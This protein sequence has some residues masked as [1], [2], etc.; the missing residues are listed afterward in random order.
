LNQ[1]PIWVPM[2]NK[3]RKQSPTEPEELPVNKKAKEEKESKQTTVWI[4]EAMIEDQLAERG[5]T[6]H[7]TKEGVR[8]VEAKWNQEWAEEEWNGWMDSRKI[9]ND[10]SKVAKEALM[11]PCR[12][13]LTDLRPAALREIAVEHKDACIR[14]PPLSSSMMAKM[15]KAVAKKVQSQCWVQ[16]SPST[17][18]DILEGKVKASAA[19][20]PQLD[21]AVQ[22]ALDFRTHTEVYPNVPFFMTGAFKCL[23]LSGFATPFSSWFGHSH[24]PDPKTS[25]SRCL[26]V[27]RT[28]KAWC[29]MRVYPVDQQPRI[30]SEWYRTISHLP[31]M[32]MTC[33]FIVRKVAVQE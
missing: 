23:P 7:R 32:P 29:D 33:E 3:K 27:Q 10:G 4:G 28:A 31:G 16:L 19:G 24:K 30:L 20:A 1:I 13:R 2:S 14:V 15:T 25:L 18:A 21:S 5:M 8:A 6:V 17:L 22:K 11:F 12:I 9:P 26:M